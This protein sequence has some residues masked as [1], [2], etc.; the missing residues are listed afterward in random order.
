MMGIRSKNRFERGIE[1]AALLGFA[2]L[3]FGPGVAAPGGLISVSIVAAACVL[4]LVVVF[5]IGRI[6]ARYRR[7]DVT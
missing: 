5:I 2:G 6:Y 3:I 4:Y 7:R 1:L